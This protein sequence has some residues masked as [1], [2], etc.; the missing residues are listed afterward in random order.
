MKF[1][2]V[3]NRLKIEILGNAADLVDMEMVDGARMVIGV[4]ELIRTLESG[5]H[6]CQ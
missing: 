4:G 1:V 3:A 6:L 5:E 2:P